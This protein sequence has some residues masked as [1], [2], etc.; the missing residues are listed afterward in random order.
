MNNN[1]LIETAKK[2]LK[3]ENEAINNVADGLGEDFINAL[4]LLDGCQGKVIVTGLGKSGIAGKKIAATFAATGE[5]AFFLHSAE[6]I[7]GDMGVVS[8]GDVAVCLS[9]SGETRELIDLIPRFKRLGV[10]I[11]AMTGNTNSSLAKLANCVLDVSVPLHPWPFGIIPTSSNAA[12]VALGDALAVALLESREIKEE[13]F[14]LLHPGGLLGQ[15]MLVKVKDLMHTGDELPIVSRD[16]NMKQVLMEMTAKRL[17]VACV[18]TE[19]SSKLE[20][21]KSDYYSLDGVVTDGDLRRLFEQHSN[22]LDLTAAEAMTIEPKTI[23]PD[24]LAASALHIMESSSITTLP[25]VDET[26]ALVGLIHLH[27]ILKLET[28][29]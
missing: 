23:L 21:S 27:D 16:T 14:A 12:T 4:K 15:K 5:P 22:P 20:H 9:Y 8:A 3:F 26:G 6:A 28:S 13:D 24:T 19:R 11:I 10:P 17:G 29:K 25:V 18:I 1:H 2:L 7:H